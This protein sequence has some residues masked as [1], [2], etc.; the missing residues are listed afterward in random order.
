ME[1][2]SVSYLYFD[3]VAVTANTI[4]DNLESE[5]LSILVERELPWNEIVDYLL[6]NESKFDGLILDWRLDGDDDS[7]ANF[8][9]EA[10]AQECRRLQVDKINNRGFE[11]SFPIILCSSESGF[12]AIHEKDTTSTDLFDGI[13]HK[14]QLE[15]MEDFLL[16]LTSAYKLLGK[17][18]VSIQD[19]I[20]LS[21]DNQD[22]VNVDLI[23]KIEHVKEKQPHETVLFL[24]KEVLGV[25][26]ALIDIN[27][28]SARLG[29]NNKSEGW[30]ELLKKMDSFKYKGVLLNEDRWWAD[31]IVEWWTIEFEGTTMKF[32]TA[33]ERIAFLE[34]KYEDLKGLLVEPKLS[35]GA[36]SKEFWTACCATGVPI[37]EVDGFVVNM[38]LH[39][40]W[41]ERE[42][43]CLDEAKNED[44]K[45][46]KWYSLLPYEEERLKSYYENHGE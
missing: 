25:K 19:V 5:N 14:N 26:G 41:Q 4:K 21:V 29:V 10:L 32:L 38:H 15:D 24:I 11:K 31:L 22:I 46:D 2:K 18:T 6:N 36:E 44:Y 28:L 42:Y 20:G 30:G 40:S 12:E 8:S 17:Q 35:N 33:A 37:A 39:Y 27:V 34:N 3:D 23:N 9:S 7:K 16:S 13:F 1:N 45:E 43:V